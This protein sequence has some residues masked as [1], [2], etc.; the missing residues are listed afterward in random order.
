MKNRNWRRTEDQITKSQRRKIS[1]LLRDGY[2]PSAIM[3]RFGLTHEEQVL[4]AYVDPTVSTPSPMDRQSASIGFFRT[5]SGDLYRSIK[6]QSGGKS[7]S[8]LDISEYS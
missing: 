5:T 8:M 2:E 7:W 3:E 6:A 1:E 4:D